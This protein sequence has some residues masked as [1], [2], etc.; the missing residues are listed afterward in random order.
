MYASSQY[1]A[2]VYRSENDFIHQN[3]E[4]VEKIFFTGEERKYKNRI[5]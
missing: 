2:E 5:L 3:C 1:D 4:F